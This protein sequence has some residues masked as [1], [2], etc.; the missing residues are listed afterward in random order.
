MP[1][2]ILDTYQPLRFAKMEGVGLFP[3]DES[4]EAV[5][6]AIQ[7]FAADAGKFKFWPLTAQN[8]PKKAVDGITNQF[9]ERKTKY[10]YI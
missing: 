1:L 5:A 6:K 8:D 4:P 3:Q 9:L 10:I 7:V 2:H